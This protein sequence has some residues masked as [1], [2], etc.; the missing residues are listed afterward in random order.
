[1]PE[2]SRAEFYFIAAMMFLILV[3]CVVSV[4]VFF[5]T[6][7][8]EMREKEARR[9]AAAKRVEVH[10]PGVNNGSSETT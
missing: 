3:L 8:K 10:N 5:R 1:M 9:E 2:T 6:Y 7:R 4:W